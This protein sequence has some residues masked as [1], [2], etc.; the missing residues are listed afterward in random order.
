[1]T[2]RVL[3]GLTCTAALV[4]HLSP[5]VR[6]QELPV[7]PGL[8]TAHLDSYKSVYHV[9]EPI[10]LALWLINR[11][12]QQIDVGHNAP[13]YMSDL[14][15]FDAA[16]KAVSPS[17]GRGP[18]WCQGMILAIPLHSAHPVLVQYNDPRITER[19]G[20][21]YA[22]GALRT[23]ADIKYWGYVL[24]QPGSYSLSASLRGLTAITPGGT[25]FTAS[26][27]D[28]SNTVRVTIIP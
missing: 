22:V 28:K 26:P 8:I 23:W 21:G 3:I 7:R 14:E 27:S 2:R 15:V 17:V 4:L 6:A 16:G 9:G 12:S 24:Q 25:A 18:C 13:Y 20:L 5:T 19:E 10:L 1:M 11:T